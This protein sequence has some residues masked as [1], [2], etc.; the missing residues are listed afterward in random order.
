[1]SAETEDRLLTQK[2]G[3]RPLPKEARTFME[4]RFGVDFG[5][6]RVHVDGEAAKL[7]HEL[8]AQAFTHGADIFFASGRY[9]PNTDTGKRLLAHELA[10]VVQQGAAK[11]KKV[12]QPKKVKGK[13][14]DVRASFQELLDDEFW[15]KSEKER[16]DALFQTYVQYAQDNN[17]KFTTREMND[18]PLDAKMGNPVSFAM[19]FALLIHEFLG[20]T[21]EPR[22]FTEVLGGGNAGFYTVPLNQFDFID[23]NCPGNLKAPD[24]T[25]D[26][27]RRLFFTDY[28]VVEVPG[29]GVYDPLTGLSDDKIL[30]SVE[31]Q[32]FVRGDRG[33]YEKRTGQTLQRITLAERGHKTGDGYVLEVIEGGAQSASG[34]GA[35]PTEGNG[36]NNKNQ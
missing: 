10:H 14:S 1:V 33:V 13:M 19:E 36:S 5:A 31:E 8:N 20:L 21:T 15:A 3:G 22:R 29:V 27:M 17:F 2:Q 34:P 28:V 9:D 32:G 30:R 16:V 35:E 6:V 25:Y 11:P 12:Q 4:S 18:M 7:S 23:R 26:A 24:G